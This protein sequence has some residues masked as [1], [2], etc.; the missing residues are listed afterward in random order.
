[1]KFDTVAYLRKATSRAKSDVANK[2]ISMLLHEMSRR[3]VAS[4]GASAND[5]S[6]A[7]QVAA[8]FGDACAYCGRVL[9]A[10]RAAVEHLEGMNRFRVGLHIPGNVVVACKR[11]NSSKRLDDQRPALVLV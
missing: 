11:C 6:Y 5:A 9:E 10:D 3:V 2:L 8:T 1:M 4:L 7:K